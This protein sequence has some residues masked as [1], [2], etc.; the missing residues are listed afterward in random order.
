MPS[1]LPMRRTAGKKF[2]DPDF[3]I[4]EDIRI[5]QSGK[6]TL[7]GFFPNK[8]LVVNVPENTPNPTR[9]APFYIQGLSILSYFDDLKG[10][11]TSAMKLIGP[12][13]KE[14]SPRIQGN[15]IALNAPGLNLVSGFSAFPVVGFG[16][17]TFVVSID[18]RDFSCTFEVRRGTL[19]PSPA[20][21]A[22][23]KSRN[24]GTNPKQ[25]KVKPRIL[26]NLKKR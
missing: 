16:K 10:D 6:P 25:K 3:F 9:I 24:I 12:D 14:L 17:Y 11:H 7:L 4:A 8:I 22:D 23:S 15:P 26:K 19:T 13:R 21:I 2:R 20:L 1:K 5:E 18:D